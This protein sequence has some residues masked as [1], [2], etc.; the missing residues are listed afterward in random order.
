MFSTSAPIRKRTTCGNWLVVHNVKRSVPG[1]YSAIAA[2]G[3]IGLPIRRLLTRLSFAT[4][5][6]FRSDVRELAG[7]PQREAIGAGLVFGDRRARLHRVADQTIIDEA[8]LCD[9][10]RFPI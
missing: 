7:G 10:R 3:S 4:C 1:S 6:A 9:M 8:Q 2:R 5:A